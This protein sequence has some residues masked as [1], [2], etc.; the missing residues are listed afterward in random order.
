MPSMRC[1]NIWYEDYSPKSDG[2]NFCFYGD[3]LL[4]LD[5]AVERTRKQPFLS[6][7][8]RCWTTSI[9]SYLRFCQYSFFSAAVLWRMNQNLSSSGMAGIVDTFSQSG[10]HWYFYAPPHGWDKWQPCSYPVWEP[11]QSKDGRQT[12]GLIRKTVYSL[13]WCRLSL[14]PLLHI[15]AQRFI[16]WPDIA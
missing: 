7:S 2:G 3:F 11:F 8:W 9:I 5:W 16:S 15:F 10:G 13:C 6:I 12:Y 14:V 1:N 4:H